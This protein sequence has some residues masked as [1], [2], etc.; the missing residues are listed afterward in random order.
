MF[1]EYREKFNIPVI[2]NWKE[3]EATYRTGISYV[4]ATNMDISSGKLLK[5]YRK[6]GVFKQDIT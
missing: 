1:Q 3:Y 5:Y 6:E 2:T 4:F